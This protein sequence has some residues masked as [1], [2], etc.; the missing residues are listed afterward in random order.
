MTR[1]KPDVY[2]ILYCKRHHFQILKRKNLNVIPFV[3]EKYIIIFKGKIIE[4]IPFIFLSVCVLRVGGG[5][6][7]LGPY[8]LE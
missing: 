3:I 6:S 8:D 7:L 4:R 5:G 1:K 2:G